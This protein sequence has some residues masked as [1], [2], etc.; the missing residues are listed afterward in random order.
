[1]IGYKHKSAVTSVF[2][3]AAGISTWDQLKEAFMSRHS[4]QS[5]QQKANRT[6]SRQRLS[7]SQQTKH[8][9][10]VNY[11]ATRNYLS[12]Q[13]VEERYKRNGD[14]EIHGAT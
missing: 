6:L 10:E 13:E 9:V 11:V 2:Y 1:M 14:K 5:S 8:E 7:L 12:Q 4:I 3:A